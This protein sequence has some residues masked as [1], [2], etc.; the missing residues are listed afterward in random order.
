M[1]ISKD[2]GG[3]KGL[4]WWPT[5]KRKRRKGLRAVRDIAGETIGLFTSSS[6]PPL[7]FNSLVGEMS[8]EK[9]KSKVHKLSLRGMW[10]LL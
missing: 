9:D 2:E 10:L 1:G 3:W 8:V 7:F 6:L 4:C 5:A